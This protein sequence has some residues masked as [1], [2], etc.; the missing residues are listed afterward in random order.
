[1]EEKQDKTQKEMESLV[2]VNIIYKLTGGG[3]DAWKDVPILFADDKRRYTKP[4]N[5][6]VPNKENEIR[7]LKKQIQL[8]K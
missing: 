7:E 4:V 8:L 6:P 5:G 3:E 2:D 1:L